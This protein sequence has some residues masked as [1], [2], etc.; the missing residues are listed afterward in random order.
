MDSL[1]ER[2]GDIFALRGLISD[3]ETGNGGIAVVS[4]V[5][6]SG[7]TALLQEA[8]DWVV[9]RG[10]VVVTV[11]CSPLERDVP[12]AA[13][14][15]LFG[16]LPLGPEPARRLTALLAEGVQ[17]GVDEVTTAITPAHARVAEGLWGLLASFAERIPVVVLV[18]DVRN[19]DALSLAYLLYFIRRVRSACVTMVLADTEDPQPRFPLF[20]AEIMRLPALRHI[21]TGPL[22]PVGTGELLAERLGAEKAA[23]LG[24]EF[25]DVS[26][27]S[28]LLLHAL[29]RDLADSG[30]TVRE[31]RE[32][33]VGE[34]FSQAVVTCLRRSGP[35]TLEAARW[36]ALLGDSTCKELLAEC[37]DTSP[38]SAHRLLRILGTVGVTHGGRFRHPAA[39]VTVMDGIP[40]ENRAGMQLRVARL[41]YDMGAPATQVASR[42]LGQVGQVE[43]GTEQAAWTVSVLREAADRALTDNRVEEAI[44]WLRQ[45]HRLCT[46]KAERG[47]ILFHLARV[48]W[49]HSPTAALRC[50]DQVTKPF[51]QERFGTPYTLLLVRYLLRSGRHQEA[52]EILHRLHRESDS[53]PN[54]VCA[55]LRLL[56]MWLAVSFP[57]VAEHFPYDHG[58]VV[59]RSGPVT[60]RDELQWQA[61][62]LLVG[63]LG[64]GADSGFISEVEQALRLYQ[65]TEATLEPLVMGLSALIFADRLDSAGSWCASLMD[66]VETVDAPAWRA[67]LAALRA[68]IAVRQGDLKGA[69]RLAGQAL[70]DI[71]AEGWGVEIGGLLSTLVLAH[72]AMGRTEE[73]DAL[74]Q[75][76]AAD[77][78]HESRYGLQY[79]YARAQHHL[80]ADRPHAALRDFL[81]CGTLMRRWN[82]DAPGLALWRAG[83]A[84]ALLRMGDHAR[85]KSL[86]DEQWALLAGNRTSRSAGMALR[87]C[88]AVS[89]PER[90]PA[91]LRQSAEILQDCGDRYELARTMAD[92]A[93]AHEALGESARARHASRKAL[94]LAQAC[95]A[96]GIVARLHPAQTAEPTAQTDRQPESEASPAPQSEGINEL[97]RAESKVAAL[98]SMGYSNR[99]IGDRL[100]VTISTV[101]QH[102]TRVYRK[103]NVNSRED[104]PTASL[105]PLV[106]Y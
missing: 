5:A 12:L 64:G 37:L 74:L 21:R 24:A 23:L 98:A 19:S 48:Q 104:L 29:L 61:A 33:V 43:L 62:R 100:H 65:V 8:A 79:R 50:L 85:A 69:V 49:R 76:P 30:S 82:L 99:E 14:R 45:A 16:A 25:H 35:K 36:A 31:Q 54:E 66:E 52:Q 93:H 89:R 73:A 34:H 57:A 38:E 75:L 4:G 59:R 103:L 17:V 96:A 102:L 27:G 55:E 105:Q 56:E 2:K 51:V 11:A 83:A 106:S 58:L 41:L 78:M 44:A 90:R 28:P 6:G 32:P 72:V 86:M 101:E 40:E 94:R 67:S 81:D 68:E 71:D 20:R 9:E 92:L 70:D 88:A 91:L 46:D 10:L 80:A 39:R 42:L 97:S 63:V 53:L 7:K 22:S 1:I 47:A 3:G 77:P 95:G 60:G 26:G 84:E 18:D 13:V 15:Q 87:V